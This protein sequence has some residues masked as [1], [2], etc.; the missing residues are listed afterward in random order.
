LRRLIF[1][2]VLFSAVSFIIYQI[3]Q[4]AISIANPKSRLKRD[5]KLLQKKILP[6][7]DNLVPFTDE[8]IKLLSVNKSHQRKSRGLSNTEEGIFTSI[9]QEESLAYMYKSYGNTGR[10]I[11]LAKTLDNEYAYLIDGDNIN[12]FVNDVFL[13]QI[14]SKGELFSKDQKLLG[15]I[16]GDDVLTTHPVFIGDREVGEVRNPMKIDSSTNR[17]YI[18]VEDMSDAEKEI[19]LSLTLVNL[20]LESL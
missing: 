19:F 2:A 1:L 18:F 13:G 4:F 10:A 15:R 11:L 20:V 14:N 3:L 9:Y 6:L 16:E 17:V 7:V 12:A 5:L 8:E